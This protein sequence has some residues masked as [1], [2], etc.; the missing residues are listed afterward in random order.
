MRY[1]ALIIVLLVTGCRTNK[2]PIRLPNVDY[3]QTGEPIR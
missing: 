2:N 1:L 3:A